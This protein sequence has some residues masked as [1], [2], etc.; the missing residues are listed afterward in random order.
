L[1]THGFACLPAAELDDLARLEREARMAKW[2]DLVDFEVVP[3]E[4]SPRAVE[5]IAPRL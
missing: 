4:S 5:R 2:R 3:V 1:E